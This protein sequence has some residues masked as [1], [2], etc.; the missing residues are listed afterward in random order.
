MLIIKKLADKYGMKTVMEK[1]R[2][3]RFGLSLL[4]I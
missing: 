4:E 1:S 3:Y 2:K